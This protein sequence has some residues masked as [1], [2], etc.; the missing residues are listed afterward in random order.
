M[1]FFNQPMESREEGIIR[2]QVKT[3][4]SPAASRGVKT[5]THEF[6][7]R[8]SRNFR[9]G[10]ACYPYSCSN[11]RRAVRQPFQGTSVKTETCATGNE[12][13]R[14][15]PEQIPTLR[16]CNITRILPIATLYGER[17][18]REQKKGQGRN[19]IASSQKSGNGFPVWGEKRIHLSRRSGRDSRRT[20]CATRLHARRVYEKCNHDLSRSAAAL[21]AARML[22][23]YPEEA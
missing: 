7:I 17:A 16:S 15:P 11:Q 20:G 10:E 5:F 23:K 3:A 21:K 14:F 18:P 13:K 4:D 9:G 2:H 6:H 8:R 19:A 22:R 1:S 12:I